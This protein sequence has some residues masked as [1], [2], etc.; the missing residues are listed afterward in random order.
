MLIIMLF[1]Q[2]SREKKT[3][4]NENFTIWMVWD[5]AERSTDLIDGFK[6]FSKTKK[7]VVIESF[8]NYEEYSY[9][10]TNAI[11]NGTAPD[12]FVL[13]SNEKESI[14]QWQTTWIEPDIVNPNSFRKDYKTFLSDQLIAKTDKWVDYLVW[15]PVWYEVLWV[16]YNRRFVNGSDVDSAS[17]LRSAV[18][19]LKE[20]N[21]DSIPVA[22][23]N[24]AAVDF[25][26]DIATQ[27][28]L[29][30][31]EN[32][33]IEQL[34]RKA[35]Q[36]W[37]WNYVDF[38][39]EEWDNKYN[40]R[41][42]EMKIA[43][44]TWVDLFSKGETLIIAGYPRL[45]EKISDKWFSSNFLAAAPFP[46]EWEKSWKALVNYNYFVIN[47]DTIRLYSVHFESLHLDDDHFSDIHT[48]RFFSN[49]S[50]RFS[51]QQEQVEILEENF[52]KCPY[53]KIV[54]GDFN[55]DWIKTFLEAY[56]YYL[57]G[58]SEFDKW[59]EDQKIHKNYNIRI[60]DFYNDSLEYTTFDKWLKTD[61][62]EKLKAML[63]NERTVI[64][65]FSKLQKVT[66]CRTSKIFS[67]KD[68]WKDC[69]N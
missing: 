20:K 56:P 57:P 60:A 49:I 67:Q 27:F 68:I 14:F 63:D 47:K 36:K 19:K 31:W 9:A 42:E 25:A 4:N 3:A 41:L 8:N 7:D 16:F 34:D 26:E 44:Q 13:N 12:V 55:N 69:D 51:R 22:I 39:D 5:S 64:D 65:E 29:T 52:K 32:R 33:S 15:M 30:A 46:N 40:T 23:W 62:D 17:S 58:V 38:W 45:I 48:K 54:C 11:A 1:N 61:Y 35:I 2:K 28:I 37:L 50:S 43:K 66:N 59:N 10:L 53:K 21:P 24:W 6:K 18:K